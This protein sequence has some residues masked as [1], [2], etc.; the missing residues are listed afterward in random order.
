LAL[1]GYNPGPEAVNRH[2][3]IFL[4]ENPWPMRRK[5]PPRCCAWEER[6]R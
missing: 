1:V 4:A 3:G 6:L 5:C 2:D